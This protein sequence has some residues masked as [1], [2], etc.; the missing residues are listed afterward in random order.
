MMCVPI[1]ASELLPVKSL[2]LDI[3]N[4]REEVKIE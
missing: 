4:K 3:K 2:V 1:N